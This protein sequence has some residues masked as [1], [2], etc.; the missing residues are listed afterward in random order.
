MS[1]RDL[2]D[3][4][5]RR[6]RVMSLVF[7]R[8]WFSEACTGS[9]VHT[10]F[11]SKT[12]RGQ[13]TLSLAT[14]GLSAAVVRELVVDDDAEAIRVTGL[15]TTVEDPVGYCDLV[16]EEG[17]ASRQVPINVERAEKIHRAMRSDSHAA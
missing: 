4:P 17:G 10:V 13:W 1:R 14:N 8:L 6:F 9:R 11:V 15:L 2:Q 12:R 16:T 3:A 5:L 7:E